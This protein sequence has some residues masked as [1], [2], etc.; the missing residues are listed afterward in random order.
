MGY[1]EVKNEQEDCVRKA[2]ASKLAVEGRFDLEGPRV[3]QTLEARW[4]A[5]T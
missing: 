2:Q 5:K 4:M 1:S 3:W